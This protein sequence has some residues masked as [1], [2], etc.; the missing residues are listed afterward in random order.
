MLVGNRVTK[1]ADGNDEIREEEAERPDTSTE[2]SPRPQV[3]KELDPSN[4][5]PDC[6]TDEQDVDERK[7]QHDPAEPRVDVCIDAHCNGEPENSKTWA[8]RT[9]TKRPRIHQLFTTTYAVI[10]DKSSLQNL[11]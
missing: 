6:E 2:L 10:I 5:T 3:V 9:Q 11:L 8:K 1:H 7:V 4:C